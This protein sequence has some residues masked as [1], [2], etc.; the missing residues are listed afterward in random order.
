MVYLM[1]DN[2]FKVRDKVLVYK[3]GLMDQNML[4]NGKI[5]KPMDRVFYIMQMVMFTKDNGLMI[6]LVDKELILTKT[7]PNTS[8][9]G[10]TINK[11]DMV[12]NNGLMDKSMKVNTKMVQ[13]QEKEF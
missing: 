11:T 8:V 13:R 4:V 5:I 2:G 7:A 10:K 6:K 3:Y 1:K 9:N 12:L